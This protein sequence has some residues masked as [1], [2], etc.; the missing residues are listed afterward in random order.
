MKGVSTAAAV[1][2]AA[3]AAPA[4]ATKDR[5]NI[6]FI[7]SDDVGY[8]DLGCYG[9]QHVKTPNL[10]RL[11]REGVRCSDAHSTSSVCTPSRYSLLTGEYAWRNPLGDHILSGLEPLS[12]NPAT[13][14]TPGLLKQ[15]GYTTGLVGKWHLGLGSKEKPV[16][17]NGEIAPGPLEA[18]FDYA[19]FYA[20]T[21]DRVPCVYIENRRVVG[22]DPGDPIEVSYGGP[23]GNDP[24]GKDHPELL[25]IKSD[26]SHAKTIVNGVSRIGYMSGGQAARWVDE[27]MADTFTGKAVSFIER[28]KAEPFFLYFAPH[29][30]HEPMVPHPRFIGT[31][32]CGTRGDVIHELDWSVGQILETLDRLGLAENTLIVYSSDNG[33]AIKDTYDDGTN[34]EHGKQPPNGVLRGH[35][36]ELYEGGHRVPLLARWPGGIPAGSTSDALIGLVDMLPTFAAAVGAAV[37]KGAGP[38]SVNVLSALTGQAG[39]APPREMLVLHTNANG[40]LGLRKGPWMLVTQS[41]DNFKKAELYNL[42]DDLAETKNIAKEYPERV[43]ELIGLLEAEMK[44]G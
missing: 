2:L 44:K 40:P 31:S 42:K 30:I 1:A 5:P 4:A 12:I 20:A 19:Y 37:P 28:H 35:K 18:G 11:A 25:K 9:A 26:E 27:D 13:T 3:K 7:L 16:D 33:G 10:D 29:D 21:N 43:R 17:Y 39:G 14:T 32:S 41:R 6:I 24:T 8:G 36:N 22:L 23:V 38:D 15:A 34:A